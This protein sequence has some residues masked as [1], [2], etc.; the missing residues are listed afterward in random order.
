LNLGESDFDL[1]PF[2]HEK[3]FQ[4]TSKQKQNITFWEHQNFVKNNQ[5]FKW[6]NLFK[7]EI[8]INKK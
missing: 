5:K 7:M 3:F 4:W 6:K 1:C 2:S 8:R